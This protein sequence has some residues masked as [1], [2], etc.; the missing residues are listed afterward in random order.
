MADERIIIR[1]DIDGLEQNIQQI[2][3]L[4][5]EMRILAEEKKK[6]AKETNNLKGATVQETKRYGELDEQIKALRREKTGLSRDIKKVDEGQKANTKTIEGLTK[7]NAQL[8]AEMRKL[9]LTTKSGKDRMKELKGEFLANDKQVRQFNESLGRH[10][11]NVGNYSG[12]I[13]SAGV[14]L[15]AMVAGVTAAIGAFNRINQMMS[16]SIR[17]FGEQEKAE[18][19]LE[20]A[21]GGNA[22]ALKEQAAA[23]QE[24]S[25]VGDEAILGQQA[26]LA[27]LG[28]TEQ[29]IMDM[30]QASVDLSAATGMNLDSAVRNLAKTYSG[31]TGELG[32]SLPMLRDLTQEELKAGAA[33]EVIREQ[34]AGTAKEISQTGIGA[35]EQMENAYGDLQERL[36]EKLLPIQLKMTEA[37]LK[38]FELVIKFTED[39]KV[40]LDALGDIGT[41]LADLK[42]RYEEAAE[43]SKGLRSQITGYV[44]DQ[45]PF[46]D[47][48]TEADEKIQK[49]EKGFDLLN[50]PLEFAKASLKLYKDVME[51]AN[52]EQQTF[53]EALAEQQTQLEQ[54]GDI[55]ES[56]A[57]RQ[58]N[59][60]ETK[61][62][63]IQAEIEA[64]LA[65]RRSLEDNFGL[66]S[67][68]QSGADAL[69]ADLNSNLEGFQDIRKEFAR[70]ANI[71]VTETNKQTTATQASTDAMNEQAK[72]ME[73]P[74]AKAYEL[75]KGADAL[76]Q[77]ENELAESL[78]SIDQLLDEVDLSFEEEGT[79]EPPIVS[80]ADL[81][82]QKLEKVS[83]ALESLKGTSLNSAIT[84]L[85]QMTDE[86]TKFERAMILVGASVTALNDILATRFANQK[87][88]I[89][90]QALA[91][92][93]A[94]E[95]TTLSEEE[96]R[97]RIERAEQK[98]ATAIE[99]IEQKQAKQEKANAIIQSLINTAL[100]I[101]NA[102]A[103][104]GP[105]AFTVIPAIAA[106]GA[107]QTGIIAA[108]QFADGGQVADLGSGEGGAIPIG[109][110]NIPALGNGDNVLATV[111]TGEVILNES[112]QARLKALTG[113]SNVFRS[114]GVPGFADGGLVPSFSN[115]QRSTASRIEQSNA[116]AIGA[117]QSIKVVNVATET[118]GMATMVSNIETEATFG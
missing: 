47:G 96:K 35:L 56:E 3:E 15:G 34:F 19:Q 67:E 46:L 43:A 37:K 62:K 11:H 50:N 10:Q 94:I 31:L 16:E 32:E 24:N 76:T 33:T 110:Q 2:G 18:R 51:L 64:Q 39:N 26:Y 45:A 92:K 48:L 116:Q 118:A 44:E 68:L 30:I 20:F 112:Q 117:M 28:F 95:A 66:T 98:K 85:S 54:T 52:K 25:T 59:L 49:V 78:K 79:G 6:L 80:Q 42:V 12:A 115:T 70:A 81:A 101:T 58:I 73:G 65:L 57:R 109:A 17:L 87:A 106:I 14:A 113:S 71:S 99:K 89:E 9:D 72:A 88:R 27:S 21:I 69:L 13:K 105:F 41:F 83:M 36:G 82:A 114:I 91:E 1:L 90:Q 5:R 60:A 107:V 100:G 38:F 102:L 53:A 75:A 4:E 108:Q 22:K 104:L 77:A 8:T 61:I 74:A 40:Y 63:A 84:Q 86:T 55:S 29:Q 103:T 23:I 111:R 97:I 7:R 93:E